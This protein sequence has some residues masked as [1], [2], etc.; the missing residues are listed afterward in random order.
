MKGNREA[1]LSI[2]KAYG[3]SFRKP[4][5]RHVL[6]DKT[7]GLITEQQLMDKMSAALESGKP[8]PEWDQYE[9]PPGSIEERLIYN[10]IRQRKESERTIDKGL[11]N[12]HDPIYSAGLT[13]S[14]INLPKSSSYSAKADSKSQQ[15]FGVPLD[16][17][18]VALKA[19]HMATER[20]GNTL[21]GYQDGTTTRI[22][23]DRPEDRKTEDGAIKAVVTIRTELPSG[24]SSTI[25]KP[26]FVDNLNRMTTLGALMIEGG[27]LVIGSRITLYE[28]E[29]AWDLQA[30]L[31]VSEV[32]SST[33]SMLGAI[34]WALSKER[35]ANDSTLQSSWS[36]QDLEEVRGYLSHISVCTAGKGGLTAEF[37][38]RSDSISAIQGDQ[39][40]ALWRLIT[41]QPHPQ[42]GGGLFCLLEM[43]HQTNNSAH[44]E[45]IIE[46]LN[47][48]E[49]APLDLPP[50]IGAWCSG[51]HGNN[52]A[53]VTF[54]PNFLHDKA[55]IA[56]NV[57]VWAVGRAQWAN[58]MLASLG[59]KVR[60]AG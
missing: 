56:V 53:Y 16:R 14:S 29:E 30:L 36:D 9:P 38:L 19:G 21:I 4:I 18:E 39:Y 22:S 1:F 60:S 37:G 48:M 8:V 59:L 49:M 40:T 52:P 47:M 44:L 51:T 42:A 32:L 11:V 26:T 31:I 41:E 12:E 13:L 10:P 6:Q 7:A 57:S 27:R 23:V 50:H 24:L 2:A 54:L 20:D 15:P 5:P 25:V 46:R 3:R 28:N 43:P 55:G 45:L 33:Q 58:A 35:R 17:L 34:R